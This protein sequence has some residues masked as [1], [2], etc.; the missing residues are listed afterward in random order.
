MTTSSI[1]KIHLVK[2]TLTII[3]CGYMQFSA[4]AQLTTALEEE[5]KIQ[6]EIDE[7]VWKPFRQAFESRD[8]EALNAIYGPEV[9]RVTPNG[10]DI[11]N[12]FKQGNIERFAESRKAGAK[13]DLDFWFEHR[14]SV[15]TASYEVGYFRISTQVDGA[16]SIF[17]GQFHIYIQKIGGQW[18]ITQDWDNSF[19]RGADVT[20]KD[21]AQGKLGPF[22]N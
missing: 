6:N 16:K 20:A 13:V 4:F 18:K 14:H 3:M 5:K 8:A 12:K 11:D 17:Y 15:P 21:F 22:N 10:L 2:I 9:I 7:Q 19:V 1:M